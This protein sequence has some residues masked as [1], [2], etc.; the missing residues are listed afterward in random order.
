MAEPARLTTRALRFPTGFDPS[1]PPLAMDPNDSRRLFAVAQGAPSCATFGAFGSADTGRL[2]L[3][4]FDGSCS[5]PPPPGGSIRVPLP[6]QRL[7]EYLPAVAFGGERLWV[8]AYASGP[9]STR[10]VAVRSTADGF[11][12]PQTSTGGRSRDGGSVGRT[13]RTADGDRPS[14]ATTSGSSRR[15]SG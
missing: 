7:P 3:C 13:H 12:E 4:F 9:R 14:S 11:G 1:E 8:A 5:G 2:P 15:A 10:L 6:G